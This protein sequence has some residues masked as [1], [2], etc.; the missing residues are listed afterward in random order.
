[1]R[2]YNRTMKTKFETLRYAF[3]KTLPILTGYI[4]LGMAYGFYGVSSGLPAWICLLTPILIY[5]G[6]MEYVIVDLLLA[7]FAPLSAFAM[8][9]M[10]QARHIFYGLGMLDKYRGMG[11]KKAYLIFAL[12]D[13]TFALL[14]SEEV[15]EDIDRGWFYFFVSLLDQ[16]YW[17]TGCALGALAGSKLPFDTTGIDFVMTAMFLVIAMNQ[18]EKEKSHTSAFIGLAASLASLLL[19]G[20]DRFLIPAMVLILA[21]LG[22][23]KKKEESRS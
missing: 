11:R 14:S 1:M 7:P 12:T 18:L 4:F 19:F 10:V 15:P 5:G 22:L 3:P 8:A 23:V 17:F 16:I 13:E 21:G 2:F 20:P 9:L 6:S